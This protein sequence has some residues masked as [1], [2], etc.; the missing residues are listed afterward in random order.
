MMVV[1]E[2]TITTCAIAGFGSFSHAVRVSST[3]AFA[4]FASPNGFAAAPALAKGLTPVLGAAST[5]G[6]DAAGDGASA[7]RRDG[8]GDDGGRARDDAR[9][10]R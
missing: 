9:D 1:N 4:G 10:E 6:D 8:D 3:G 2:S 7:R 5:N